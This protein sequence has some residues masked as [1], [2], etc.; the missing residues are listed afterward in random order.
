MGA[1]LLVR[2][3]IE[4]GRLKEFADNVGAFCEYR[5]AHHWSVPEILYGLAGPMN[6][7]VMLFRYAGSA[8]WEGELAAER[9]DAEYGKVAATLPYVKGSIVYE[10][11][12][13]GV[14]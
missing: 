6:T 10:L 14:R 4:Q 1:V 8:A 3:V 7:V 9:L 2:G 13:E 12:Q 5:R 11:F